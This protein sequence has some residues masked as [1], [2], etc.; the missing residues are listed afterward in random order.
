MEWISVWII[1]YNHSKI[2]PLTG[3]VL[4]D[5]VG[6]GW[7]CPRLLLWRPLLPKLSLQVSQQDQ[8]HPSGSTFWTW[9]SED[10]QTKWKPDPLV[11]L[12]PSTE[13]D[14]FQVYFCS[15]QTKT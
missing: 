2:I 8:L 1:T 6:P 11:S 14:P 4:Q 12:M 13:N 9:W 15:E 7:S 5:K 3:P 10:W